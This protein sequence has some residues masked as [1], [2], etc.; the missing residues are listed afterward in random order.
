MYGAEH[1]CLGGKVD[2]QCRSVSLVFFLQQHSDAAQ[3][4]PT[5]T[6]LRTNWA[7]SSQSRRRVAFLRILPAGRPLPPLFNW[8]PGELDSV[9]P[10]LV[11]LLQPRVPQ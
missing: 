1:L 10:E 4:F 3:M 6:A 9:D 5:A 11:R 2:S 8:I 7:T